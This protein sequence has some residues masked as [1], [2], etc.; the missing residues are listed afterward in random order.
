MY[1][2]RKTHLN[3]GSYYKASTEFFLISTF[4]PLMNRGK[5]RKPQSGNWPPGRD[6]NPA[7]LEYDAGKPE[8]RPQRPI[9]IINN[10]SLK[11]QAYTDI[12]SRRHMPSNL[13]NSEVSNVVSGK[14]EINGL[15]MEHRFW[16]WKEKDMA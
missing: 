5:R 9:C 2:Y 7:P 13:I 12:C 4:C 15:T 11:E 16:I 3:N 14:E 8:T 6:L 1:I 10:C